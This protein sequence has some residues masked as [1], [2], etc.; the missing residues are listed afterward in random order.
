MPTRLYVQPNQS[1]MPPINEGADDDDDDDD[2]VPDLVDGAART[3]PLQI[4]SRT[5]AAAVKRPI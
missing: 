2:D 5:G 4:C 3:P 1:G